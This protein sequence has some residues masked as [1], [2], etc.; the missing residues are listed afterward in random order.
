MQ[1][2]LHYVDDKVPDGRPTT[3]GAAS[4]VSSNHRQF[5]RTTDHAD[6]AG[7]SAAKASSP[8]LGPSG[9]SSPTSSSSANAELDAQRNANYPP[10]FNAAIAQRHAKQPAPAAAPSQREQKIRNLFQFKQK[11]SQEQLNAQAQA[12]AQQQ[13]RKDHG[14]VRP[15]FGLSLA[16]AVEMCPPDDVDVLLP[17]I[18]YRCIEYLRGKKAANEEG[19][20]RLSGSNLVVRTLKER[21][22][23][24][25]DVDLLND[26][27]YY[28]V[29]AVASLFKT[30]LR[31]LPS[32]I[33]TRDLHI[34]FLR[35]L[36]LDDKDQK[37]S[38]Y[39]ALV[40]RLPDVNYF[41]LRAM[42]EY[43]LEVVQNSDRNKMTVK[44]IGIVF[45]PTLNIPAPVFSM[46]LNDFD[47]IFNRREEEPAQETV[48]DAPRVSNDDD[49]R[50]P[51]HQMFSDLPTTPYNVN[52][53]QQNQQHHQS[54]HQQ[55]YGNPAAAYHGADPGA[56]FG[57]S[58]VQHQP[59]S[60]ESRQYVSI[61]HPQASQSAA[62]PQSM[63]PPPAPDQPRQMQYRMQVPETGSEKAKR[64]ESAM[65]FG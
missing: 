48:L 54:Q 15:V 29:H 27:E 39:N 40:H 53:F 19:L 5:L 6:A 23:T 8:T 28:D 46:F 63:Y 4:D 57:L 20:F 33:L 17:A 50:S 56:E 38:A 45:S 11:S 1:A 61:P 3:S 31:E 13:K 49:V 44:N 25:G 60:Y 42:S 59:Q 24:E 43:L 52:S 35:V 10:H 18:V 30:Y 65:F 36:E 26:D 34:E 22:N 51:R 9:S 21:F 62:P 12:Q 16:E 41:L 64:R 58:P 7:E 14:Y 47:D 2:L 32:T 37:I 55:Q